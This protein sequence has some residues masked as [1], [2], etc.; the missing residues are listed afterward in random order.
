[1]V[2][3]LRAHAPDMTGE[4][5]PGRPPGAPSRRRV[6]TVL[7]R[8][9]AI[10]I[11]FG[12]VYYTTPFRP[13]VDLGTLVRLAVGLV[14]VAALLVWQLRV[15]ARSAYP[16]LRAIETLTVALPLFLLVFAATYT[17]MSLAQPG[18]FSEDLS[19]T[20]ALYFV[21]T[22]FATVGFGD[23]SPVSG[24]ARVVVSVQMLA[25]L[26]LL[27]LVLRALLNAVERGR[28]HQRENGTDG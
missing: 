4:P 19:R 12:V 9:G 13:V 21:I 11:G 28:A 24:L 17:V 16:V 14:A 22:V 5:G 6:A 7:A 23:I 18:S 27:G 26:L 2:G 20:D 1:M 8:G 3:S 10:A 15:I 25:D